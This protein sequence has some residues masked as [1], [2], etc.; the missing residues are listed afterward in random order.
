[1]T[2]TRR[3]TCREIGGGDSRVLSSILSRPVRDWKDEAA[4]VLPGPPGS[5][6]TTGCEYLAEREG[7]HIVTAREFLTLDRHEWH[8]STPFIAVRS[9]LM[10][11]HAIGPEADGHGIYLV[12][13]FGHRNCR[14]PTP[15]EAGALVVCARDL[16]TRLV[17]TLS[18]GDR[19]RIGICVIDVSPPG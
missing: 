12:L 7:G 1:M 6:K 14:R 17:L 8:R 16:E 18:A 4:R 9:R 11:R 2:I 13:W 5:G 15:P 19:R 10:G 3:R